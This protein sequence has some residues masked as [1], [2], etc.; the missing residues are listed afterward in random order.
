[1]IVTT[2]TVYSKEFYEDKERQLIL[3]KNCSTVMVE[4]RVD[5]T[6]EK[7]V[8]FM[9]FIPHQECNSRRQLNFSVQQ[10]VFP[11]PKY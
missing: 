1:M 10:T 2:A 11:R 7:G 8:N 5:T 9:G 4:A 6:P 3:N